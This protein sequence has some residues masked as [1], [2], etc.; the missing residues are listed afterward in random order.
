M[1]NHL[2]SWVTKNYENAHWILQQDGAPAHLA[3]STQGWCLANMTDAS[4]WPANSPDLNVLYFSI[5][6]I[7][8]QKAC[9]KK[10]T[11]IQALRKCLKKAGTKFRKITAG[12]DAGIS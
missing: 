4:K 11:S 8:E 5:C 3:K 10:H 7:L 12:R 9:Q 1:K 2:L 6:A